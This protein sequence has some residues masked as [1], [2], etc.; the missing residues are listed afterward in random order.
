MG[1][2]EVKQVLMVLSGKGGVGKSSVSVQLAQGFLSKGLKVG[3]LDVDICG[4]SIP[5]MLGAEDQEIHQSEE[6]LIPVLMND[7]KLKVSSEYFDD[8]FFSVIQIGA[9]YHGQTIRARN[10]NSFATCR[11]RSKL[12]R[13]VGLDH[14]R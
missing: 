2:E 3:I 5:R 12:W 9:P 8:F 1:I 4:P 13:G 7:S 6:G 11:K 10:P 14:V